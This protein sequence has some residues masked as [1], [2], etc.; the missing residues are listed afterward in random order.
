MYIYVY[1]KHYMYIYIIFDCDVNMTEKTWFMIWIK[2]IIMITV[3]LLQE[4]GGRST[5]SQELKCEP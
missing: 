2:A 1:I 5:Y 3:C 4:V